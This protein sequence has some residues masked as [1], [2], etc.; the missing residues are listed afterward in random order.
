[1]E[2]TGGGGI[3]GRLG[4]KM[5]GW[6]ALGLLIVLAIAIWRMDPVVRTAIWQGIWRTILWVVIVAT[7]PWSARLF[8]RRI[9]EV[10]SNWAGVGLLAAFVAVDLG[11]GLLMVSG[12]DASIEAKR[13]AVASETEGDAA[14]GGTPLPTAP[15]STDA[16]GLVREKLAD[17]AEGAADLAQGAAERL[18]GGEDGDLS[19]EE[20]DAAAAETE[21]TEDETDRGHGVW[22]WFACLAAL[23]LAGTYNY[24]VTEYLAE[25]SGG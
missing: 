5:L 2:T 17:V 7:L 24:L 16:T 20:A 9:L 10:G 3:L 1:M 11:V 19:G 12:C 23:A 18:R 21:M 22:F 8:I 4:E 13:R 6:I 15:P 14:Q 25:M